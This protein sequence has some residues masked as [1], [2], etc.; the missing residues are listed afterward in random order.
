VKLS[1]EVVVV[2]E[3][4]EEVADSCR[5]VLEATEKIEMNT[6]ALE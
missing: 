5:R 3:N 2:E 6:A 1:V 4:W